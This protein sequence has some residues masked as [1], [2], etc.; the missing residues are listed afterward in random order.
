MTGPPD[1]G[2]EI[3]DICGTVLVFLFRRCLF[4]EYSENGTQRGQTPWE[5]K[6][7]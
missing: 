7:E 6:Y 5:A 2:S 3:I 4:C 1:G